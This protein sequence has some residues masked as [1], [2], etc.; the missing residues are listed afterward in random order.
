M[1]ILYILGIIVFMCLSVLFID[2]FQKYERSCVD[3]N[4]LS[5]QIED[6]NNNLDN[7]INN[8]DK[9][10][11]LLSKIDNLSKKVLKFKK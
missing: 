9:K 8:L 3:F 2:L 7:I 10:Q 4:A 6:V 5:K 1:I 11:N